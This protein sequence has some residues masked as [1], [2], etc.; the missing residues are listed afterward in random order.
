MARVTTDTQ[1]QRRFSIISTELRLNAITQEWVVIAPGRARRP[2]EYAAAQTILTSQRASH[3]EDCPFCTGSEV[4]TPD[5]T[6]RFADEQSRWLVR[7]FP[8]RYP[9][10]APGQQEPRRR[11]DRFH[12]TLE[13]IGRHEVVIESPLHNTT[14]ALQS[15]SEVGLVLRAWRERYRILSQQPGVEHVVIF[16]NHGAAAGTSLE[17]PHSQVVAMPVL[18]AQIRRRL[19]EAARAYHESGRCTFCQMLSKEEHSSERTIQNSRFFTSFVPFAASSPYCLWLFPYRHFHSFAQLNDEELDDLAGLLRDVLRRLYFGL[20]DPAYNLVIRSAHPQALSS[21]LFHFYLTVVPR[22]SRAAGFEL[23]TGMFINPSRPE[24]D[25]AFL[26]SVPLPPTL[27]NSNLSLNTGPFGDPLVA[28]VDEEGLDLPALPRSEV[29]RCNLLHRTV[30]V[31]VRNHHGE[32][33][34]HQR[35]AE[36]DYFPNFYSLFVTGIVRA[37]ETYEEAASAPSDIKLGVAPRYFQGLS[38]T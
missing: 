28:V 21:P 31:L 22:L 11:G 18:P 7:S 16:K 13:G 35:S 17:H 8:N 12:R 5:E 32:I 1:G 25:A 10:L 30:A 20:N 38:R 29:R 27:E 15:T 33:F 36:Q 26:R 14:L 23:G 9:A 4:N 37:E 2:E 3:R 6:L 34:A 19:D 24:D